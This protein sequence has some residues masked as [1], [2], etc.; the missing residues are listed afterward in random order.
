MHPLFLMLALLHVAIWA[1]VLT[2]FLHRKA[3]YINLY[4]VIPFIYVVHC[5]PL[6]LLEHLKLRLS[7]CEADKEYNQ[8]RIERALFLPH[9]V[10]T[11]QGR[12][13]DW[14]TF[15]PI[16]PQGMLLF[17]A[18]T[19]LFRLYPPGTRCTRFP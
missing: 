10:S 4:Y 2:A 12:L 16:S 6:H 15:S 1:F 14:C 8:E 11:L 17:G 13:E 5:L 19:S 18:I 7:H 9:L 3:A